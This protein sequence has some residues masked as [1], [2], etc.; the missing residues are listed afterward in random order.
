MQKDLDEPSEKINNSSRIVSACLSFPDVLMASADQN[1]S[2]YTLSLSN[3]KILAKKYSIKFG[4]QPIKVEYLKVK[5]QK[6]S[7]VAF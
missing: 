7:I 3:S 2:Q 4:S 5:G 6:L 1:L